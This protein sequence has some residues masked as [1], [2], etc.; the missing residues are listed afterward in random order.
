M[1]KR[2][3]ICENF[4]S[5]KFRKIFDH[6]TKNSASKFLTVT[7]NSLK[8]LIRM[9]SMTMFNDVITLRFSKFVDYS[10]VFQF[11]K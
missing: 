4:I 5:K 6:D 3:F 10:E 8:V 11:G 9:T 2:D 1:F 7:E